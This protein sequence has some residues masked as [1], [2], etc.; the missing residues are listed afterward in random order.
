MFV[1]R[2]DRKVKTGNNRLKKTYEIIGT[3]M[4]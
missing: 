2:V 3:L 4:D 1:S